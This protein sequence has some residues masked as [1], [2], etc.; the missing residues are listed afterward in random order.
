MKLPGQIML[1]LGR[2]AD[3][4]VIAPLSCNTLAKM[5]TGLCDNLLLAVYLSAT[6]PVIAA[7]AMDEDMWHHASTKFNIE[8]IRSFGNKIIPVENGELASGLYGEGR[9]AEPGNILQFLDDFFLSSQELAGK[10]VLVTAGPTYE[11]I[12]PVRFIGNHSS[13]KMGIAI[14]EEFAARGAN[15]TFNFRAISTKCG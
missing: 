15:V 4:M 3:V 5:A 14:A 2:W 9:M 13:G 11:A 7:P 12:D 6:C 1:T 8:K 10:K